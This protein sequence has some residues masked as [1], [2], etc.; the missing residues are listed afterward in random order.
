MRKLLIILGVLLTSSF[1]E[2]SG[3][4]PSRM[5]YVNQVAIVPS[6]FQLHGT[7]FYDQ[8]GTLLF[9]EVESRRWT[10]ASGQAILGCFYKNSSGSNVLIYRLLKST[11]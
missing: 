8:S 6:G 2:A 10:K 11:K 4:C 1:A 7:Q 5:K 9:D 3:S